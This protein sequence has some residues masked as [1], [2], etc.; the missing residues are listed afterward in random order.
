[1][2]LIIGARLEQGCLGATNYIAAKRLLREFPVTVLQV[3]QPTPSRE[4]L[5][6][7]LAWANCNRTLPGR[8]VISQVAP[9]DRHLAMQ[10][11]LGRGYRT[12]DRV[13]FIRI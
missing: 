5:V 6:G 8:V 10:Y 4:S 12:A 7:F 1:M 3:L 2:R 11:L 9:V 13:N